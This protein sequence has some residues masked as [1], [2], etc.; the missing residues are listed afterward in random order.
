M[1]RSPLVPFA[2]ATLVAAATLALAACGG[3]GDDPIDPQSEAS[4]SALSVGHAGAFTL[5]LEKIGG[6][7]AGGEA[8]AE[9]N[10]Y[11]AHSGRLF[12]TDGARGGVNVFD[13]S[14]ITDLSAPAS[15]AAF[16]SVA[17]IGATVN[18]V[19][20]HDGLVA[21]AVESAP[22]TA[23][24]RVA[25]YRADTLERLAVVTVG[26]QPDMLV[27]THDGRRVLVANEGEPDSY[28]QPGSVDPEG[29]VSIIDV[30]RR[31]TTVAPVVR[32]ADF[33]AFDGQ[34]DALR[35][36]GVRIYGPG[37]TAAQD[38]E[39]E[40]IALDPNGHLA[41]V[42]LQE[43]NAVAT[44]DIARAKV[45]GI[46]PL[47]LKD[48]SLPGQGL[49]PSDEDGGT[50][51]NSGT[52]AVKIGSWPVMGMYLPDAIA[53]Y[54]AR[55]Q[56]Y[57][58]TANEGDARAD[59]P[60]FNEE[61]RVRA[62]CDKG[63]DPTVFAGATGDA[64]D[65]L[66]KDSNLGRL[67]I[68][69]APNGNDNGKNAAGQCNKLWSYGGRS[70]SIWRAADMMRVFDSGEDFERLTAAIAAQVGA[71]FKFNSGHDN[72]TLDSRSAAKG[73]EP[74]AVAVGEIRG[75]TYA[76]IGLERVGG[77]MVYDITDPFNARF[78]SYINTRS[79]ATG[80][81]GPE[82]VSF[83]PAHRSPTGQP[84]VI[85]SHEVSG[86][87]AVYRVVPAGSGGAPR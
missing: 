59:W 46:Q 60:G 14:G 66:L 40:Y 34:V 64:S 79:G 56:T 9:I 69:R 47:G 37:A 42:V 12:V 58:V 28:G 5:T 87:T 75:R 44:V 76:F 32:T 39:P 38:L 24:G 3:G 16:I 2:L 51:T 6:T 50:D 41:Y 35:A 43:N 49:D 7:A 83:V 21:V 82:G 19:A 63:L 71:P 52:P 27:F 30:N 15:P 1:R 73:P 67:R 18:S 74:E 53:A 23:P 70:F 4:T 29:S 13:P 77:I 65:R 48:H 25:F 80:D 62:Y 36:R 17:D 55:G 68:T 10:A 85:V 78:E 33:R 26:A 61:V 54:R 86:T 81:L 8:A 22:K 57:L 45:L 20:V 84:L 72:D 11:D 31:G